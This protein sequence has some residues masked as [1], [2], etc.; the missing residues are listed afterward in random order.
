MTAT[1][2]GA[3]DTADDEPVHRLGDHRFAVGEYVTVADEDAQVELVRK[4]VA[5]GRP[6]VSVSEGVTGLEERFLALTRGDLN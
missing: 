2:L 1:Q 4:L 5:Y 6:V 3:D